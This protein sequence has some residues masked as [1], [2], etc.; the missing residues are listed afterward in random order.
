MTEKLEIEDLTINLVKKRVRNINL[1]INQNG[2]IY[3]SCPK[4]TPLNYLLKFLNE[5][6][7]WI[8][9]ALENSYEKSKYGNKKFLEG[10]KHYLFGKE[11]TLQIKEEYNKTKIQI[12]NDTNLI[13]TVKPQATFKTKEKHLQNFYKK[14]LEIESIQYFEKWE[15]I[16]NV[17]KMELKIKKMKA[18]W[19]Y[20]DFRKKIIC[21]NIE[22][23]KRK[24][25]FVEYVILHELCHLIVPNH[26][27]EF[28]KLLNLHM[29]DWKIISKNE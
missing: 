17:N 12:E 21:L 29:P 15:E 13:M 25:E 10:E 22:L 26:G 4:N 2:E 27:N 7:D 5:K 8:K 11:L 14:N 16:L 9:K 1:R 23:A 3:V 28:K 18:K 24:R 20:C 19:G 6:K